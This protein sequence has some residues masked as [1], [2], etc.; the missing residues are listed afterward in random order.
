[1][2]RPT[3]ILILL[4]IPVCVFSQERV[5]R[6]GVVKDVIT[7]EALPGA[8]IINKT[9]SAAAISDLSGI[10]RIPVVM[11]DTL[12]ITSLGFNNRVI[13][14]NDS[15]ISVAPF[16]VKMVPKIYE[17]GEVKVNPLGSKAQFRNDFMDLELAD[18]EH[19]IIGIKKVKPQDYP[20]WEDAE[21]MKKVKHVLNPISFIYYNTNRHAKARQEYRR[22]MKN[23]Q[24]IQEGRKKF[25]RSLVADITRLP[26]DSLDLFMSYCAFTDHFL[27][28]STQY[29]V[30]ET[31]LEKLDVFRREQAV[32]VI[33][34]R[35]KP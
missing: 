22:L 30:V 3:L 23:D 28:R 5:L 14:I 26:T 12:I 1:M 18:E 9:D 20:I 4:A 25:D 8:H 27:I 6:G 19:H 7:G 31:M 16:Y 11:G 17:L 33:R 24:R 15:T 13:P 34:A 32:E 35:L 29:E 10:F 2:I 21:E